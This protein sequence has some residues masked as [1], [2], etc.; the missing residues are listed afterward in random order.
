MTVPQDPTPPV[1]VGS[2]PLN[3]QE[4]NNLIGAH[5]RG[6][7]ATKNTINQDHDWLATCDLQGAPY[8]FT[9]EQETLIKSAINDLDTA[10]DA[11]D[12]TFISR[13]TGMY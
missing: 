11:I 8:H 1:V 2:A 5:L 4:V 7:T 12:M 13:L 3:A 6:F 10:L 9:V